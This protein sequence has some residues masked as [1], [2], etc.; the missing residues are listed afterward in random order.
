MR[1]LD[2]C[3]TIGPYLNNKPGINRSGIFINLNA[4]KFGISLDLSK[5]EGRE[6]LRDLVRWG[7][8]VT[9]SFSPKAM[10]AW[11]LDYAALRKVN[12]SLIMVSSCLMG[13]TGPFSKFAGYG[14]L[15]AAM[16]GFGNLCGWPDRAPAGPYGSY[17]DCVAP[18]FTIASILAAL[19]YRRRT[20]RGQYIELSQAEASMHFLGPALLDYIANGHVETGQGNRDRHFAPHG[21]YPC[22]AEDSWIAIVC[23]TDEQWR[24]LSAL[25]DG[26]EKRGP[27]END[28]ATFARFS[29]VAERLQN[30]EHLD[31]IVGNWTRSWDALE[32]ES[33]L[34]SHGIAASKAATSDD[35]SRDPQLAWRQHFVDVEDSRLGKLVVE[36]SS[37][38]LSDT[39]DKIARSAPALGDDTNY[40]L[41]N[42]LG[43]SRARIEE[44]KARSIL[45]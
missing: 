41:E 11:G 9:E 10:R 22:A 39:P 24:V 23:T 13:Q 15:A 29:S 3:R 40:V 5:D 26:S 33:L 16:C 27:V 6:V 37:Y 38:I 35:L 32:L 20:G 44:L 25:I 21:V 34:Q 36:R 18:R 19:E 28:Y 1:R 8:I 43:Y 42:V 12:P 14:N 17:T 4:G 2:T 45:Q 31:R 30:Q 7:D